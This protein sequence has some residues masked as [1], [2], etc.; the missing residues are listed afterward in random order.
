MLHTHSFIYHPRCIMFF[1]QHFSFPCQ[2]QSTKA[3][4]S[5]IHL[6]PTLYNVFLPALQFPPVSIIPSIL[7]T[8]SFICHPRCIM[9]FSQHFSFPVS[10]NPPKLHTNSFICHQRCIM[11][12]SQHFSFPCQYHSTNA[13]YSFIHLPPT[14]YNVFFPVLLFS[15]SVSFNQ[16][17]VLISSFTTDAV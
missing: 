16:C 7:H 13:P 14:L 15:L 9:F 10:I 5:F 4:Y 3:P 17:S 8:H 11:F 2:Y 1:S 12:F 6:P